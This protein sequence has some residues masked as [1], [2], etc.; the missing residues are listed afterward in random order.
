M[1]D[2]RKIETGSIPKW[3]VYIFPALTL[4]FALFYL[5]DESRY[6]YLIMEDS[7][8][9]WL[10]FAFLIAA[11]ILSLVIAV[12]IKRRHRYFHWFF[13]LFFGFNLLAGFEEIS[14]GQRVFGVETTGIFHKYSDQNESNLHNTFQG[15]FH[16]T[17][18]HIALLAL[19]FYG[20]I[21]PV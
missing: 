14:W 18:K 7:I 17:T 4:I 10:T 9:E 8:V 1:V 15:L 3:G 13:I 16:I 6:R 5:I 2:I 20:T 21:F 19:L 12:K 11:G